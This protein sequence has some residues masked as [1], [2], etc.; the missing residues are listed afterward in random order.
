MHLS[1]KDVWL[2]YFI[3]RQHLISQLTSGD[4]L[5]ING[6][7]CTNAK[8]QSVLKFSKQFLNTIESVKQKGYHLKEAKVN[9]IVYWKKEDAENE[10]RIIF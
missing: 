2:D 6:D 8:G 5:T 4:S 3:N 9:F 10:S 1:F 7:E